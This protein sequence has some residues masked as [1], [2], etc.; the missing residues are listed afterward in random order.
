[1]VMK[2]YRKIVIDIATSRVLEADSFDYEGPVAEAKGGGSST[3]N[4]ALPKWLQPFAEQF[5]SSYQGHVFDEQGN[6]RQPAEGL[7]QEIAGFN[8][9]QQQGMSMIEMMTN[10]AQ[11][12]SNQAAYQNALSLS[13]GYLTPASNPYINAVYSAAARQVTDNYQNAVAPGIMA[14]AQKSGNFGGSAMDEAMAHS[15]YGLGENL[16]NLATSIY[17][18]N[19]QQERDRQMQAMGMSPQMMQQLY[20]PGQNLLGLGAMQ[21]GQEQQE[22]DVDYMNALN[23]TQYPFELLSGFG[24][25]LGQAGMGAGTSTVR[26]GGGGMFGKVIAWLTLLPILMTV[27]SSYV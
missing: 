25:A 8:P 10:P 22:L 2:V 26:S 21:Q 11:D 18:G 27:A 19:Y 20:A 1:M 16:N 5:I 7:N 6:V 15:R 12:L 4:T 14:A 9:L 13:G 24:G 3:T 17:G 23:E